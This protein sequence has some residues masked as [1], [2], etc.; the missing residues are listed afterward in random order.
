MISGSALKKVYTKSYGCYNSEVVQK[1]S[2]KNGVYWECRCECGKK[3]TF[4]TRSNLL[5][6]TQY[7]TLSCGCYKNE[8]L[9]IVNREEDR[10]KQIIKY[11]YGKL[12]V[13]NRRLGYDNSKIIS[14]EQ[15][16]QII[17]TKSILLN[18][19]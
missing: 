15:Y 5:S 18:I 6:K 3:N 9:H 16:S 8:G 10:E 7:K 19:E 11:L 14:L 1:D 4:V 13:R 2:T 12:K 17:K